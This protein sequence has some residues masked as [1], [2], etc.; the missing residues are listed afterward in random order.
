MHAVSFGKNTFLGG[1]DLNGKLGPDLPFYEN[2][3]LGG[4]LRLSGHPFDGLT[5]QY[6]G[7]ARLI[8]YR[9][10]AGSGSRLLGAIYAGGSIESGGVW[11]R[12]REIGRGGMIVAGSAFVGAETLLGPL[13]L[14]YGQA[15]KGNHAV[16]FYLGR[17]F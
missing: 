17:G 12:S 7:L 13:Y 11:H 1:L 10:V 14:A 3:S 16:Y 4:F 5:D 2:S 6:S 8:Y 9:R 15:E